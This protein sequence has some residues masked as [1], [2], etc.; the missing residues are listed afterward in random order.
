MHVYTYI[1]MYVYAHVSYTHT[2]THTHISQMIPH[3]Q[4]AVNMAKILLKTSQ[5]L[6]DAKDGELG[7]DAFLNDLFQ[8]INWY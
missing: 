3:H 1:R 5:P 8:V 6:I 4:N 2:H 7:A